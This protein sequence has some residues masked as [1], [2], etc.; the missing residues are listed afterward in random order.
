MA[1]QVSIVPL[2]PEH[3]E[4]AA[5]LHMAGQ[6]GTFL[7]SLGPGVLAALYRALPASAAG[8]GFAALETSAVDAPVIGFVS[9]TTN[10]GRLFVAVGVRLLPPLLAQL[11]RHPTLIGRSLQTALYPL[12]MRDEDGPAAA[13]LLSIMVEPAR[14]GQGIGA[15]LLAALVTVCRER[16]IGRLDVSVDAANRGAQ[17]FYSRHGFVV[18]RRFTLYGRVMVQYQR[19]V[20]QPASGA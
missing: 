13:E 12:Q 5:R 9:A 7:T 4:A 15:Q 3:A 2:A 6:P 19:Q 18:H 10:V 1:S 20:E 16:E 8:F 11:A 17:R 14:R